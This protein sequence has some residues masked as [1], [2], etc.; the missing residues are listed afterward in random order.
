MQCSITSART[1]LTQLPRVVIVFVLHH[2]SV[3][4]KSVWSMSFRIVAVVFDVLGRYPA[5]AP[6]LAPL[7]AALGAHNQSVRVHVPMRLSRCVAG[8]GE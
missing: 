2:I 3:R 8:W 1:P 4:F 5:L 7:L 6:L